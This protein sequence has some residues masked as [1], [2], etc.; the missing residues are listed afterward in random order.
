MGVFTVMT[1]VAAAG[2]DAI[3][4][5]KKCLPFP[6][7]LL[8]I[9]ALQ[10][11]YYLVISHAT[12]LSPSIPVEAG[13]VTSQ[14]GYAVADASKAGSE[15]ALPATGGAVYMPGPVIKTMSVVMA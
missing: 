13:Q 3:R 14:G 12:H 11:S 1:S 4:Q 6:I 7:Y 2:L 10:M 5:R 8:L 15:A 9:Y